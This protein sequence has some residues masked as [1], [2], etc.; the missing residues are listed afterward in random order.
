MSVP[1]VQVVCCTRKMK[2][3]QV[4]RCVAR[5][6]L[7]GF[8]IA[9]PHCGFC[10]FYSEDAHRFHEHPNLPGAPI[11]SLVGAETPLACFRCKRPMVIRDG[12]WE[13]AA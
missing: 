4:K 12:Y 7:I 11:R 9:C 3:G 13:P 5:G 2:P 10:V 8:W 6:P 1:V